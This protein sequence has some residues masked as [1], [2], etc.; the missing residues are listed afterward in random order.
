MRRLAPRPLS[1]ALEEVVPGV[2]PAGLLPRVQGLWDEVAGPVVAAES[3][4]TSEREGVVTVTCGSSAWAHELE[5][6]GPELRERLNAS[7]AATGTPA[8]VRELRFSA[9]ASQ[10]ARRQPRRRS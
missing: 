2:A 4:P 10:G 8:R 9:A 3:E 5:L 1:A 7:L 6:L